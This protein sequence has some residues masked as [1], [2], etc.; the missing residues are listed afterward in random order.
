M[1]LALKFTNDIKQV[2]MLE[3]VRQTAKLVIALARC[4]RKSS[5]KVDHDLSKYFQ[6][7]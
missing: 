2:V 3:S 7:V 4:V 5:S 1:S 6:W